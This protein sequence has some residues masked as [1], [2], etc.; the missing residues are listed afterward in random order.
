MAWRRT[1]PASRNAGTSVHRPAIITCGSMSTVAWNLRSTMSCAAKHT[2]TPSAIRLPISRPPSTP[3]PNMMAMPIAAT[4]SATHVRAG[5]RSPSTNQPAT[6]ASSGDT[7]IITNVFATVVC[8][9]DPMKRK[10][11]PAR[12]SPASTPGLPTE[13]H[14]ARHRPAMH[15]EKHARDEQRHEQRPPEHDL[16]RVGDRE[17]P[18]EDAAGRPANGGDDH[19]HDRA[20]VAGGVGRRGVAHGRRGGVD[21]GAGKQECRLRAF[22]KTGIGP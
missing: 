4:N 21:P 17:L 22:A 3:P 8:V 19:E 11:V 6:A 9:S 12:S 13:T 20:A 2:D 15:H 10:N 16:P 5:T 7:L 14:R 1:G 18:H